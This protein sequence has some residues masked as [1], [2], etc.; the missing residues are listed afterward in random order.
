MSCVFQVLS[1]LFNTADGKLLVSI[2]ST[3]GAL[4]MAATQCGLYYQAVG[5]TGRPVN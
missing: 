2:A 3:K 1:N 5:F 4:I